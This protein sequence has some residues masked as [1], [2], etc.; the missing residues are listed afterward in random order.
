V[1]RRLKQQ[2]GPPRAYQ[3]ETMRMLIAIEFFFVVLTKFLSM[4][5]CNSRLHHA[6]RADKT[7]IR[8]AIRLEV[9]RRDAS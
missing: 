8:R 6:N 3:I 7:V 9:R 2:H 5:R 1:R 4:R